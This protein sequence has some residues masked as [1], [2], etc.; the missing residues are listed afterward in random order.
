MKGIREL[1]LDNLHLKVLALVFALLFWFLA[2]NREIAETT[3]KL[4]V[5]P[6]PGGNYRVIDYRPRELTITVEGYRRELSRLKELPKLPIRLPSELSQE[7]GW[8]RVPLRKE[9]LNLGSS[10]RIKKISPPAIEV[11]VEKLVKRVAP[12]KVNFVGAP[13]GSRVIL[14]P[15]YA[16]VSL[17]EELASVPITVKTEKVDLTGIKLPATLVISLESRFQVEPER[18]EVKIVKGREDESQEETLRNRRNQGNSQ[19]IPPHSRDGS[20]DRNG[21]RGLPALKIPR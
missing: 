11:K 1:L 9:E 19:Q 12:I 14:K 10:V 6:V 21:L 7:R 20:E 17:P 5:E 8:V 3:L 4:K 2:T 16:V 18:V 13:Q 15:D